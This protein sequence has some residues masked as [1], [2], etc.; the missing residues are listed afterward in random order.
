LIKIKKV[1]AEQEEEEETIYLPLGC[2]QGGRAPMRRHC[3]KAVCFN[4]K[5][6]TLK[7]GRNFLLGIQE[8]LALK[9]PPPTQDFRRAIDTGLL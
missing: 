4:T 8:Y 9:K 7:I 2:L 5:A 1:H 3:Q 6:A